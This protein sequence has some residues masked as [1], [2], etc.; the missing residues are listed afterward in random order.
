MKGLLVVLRRAGADGD[1][2]DNDGELS[3]SIYNSHFSQTKPCATFAVPAGYNN[4]AVSGGHIT[5]C[6]IRPDLMAQAMEAGD[7]GFAAWFE[8]QRPGGCCA[9]L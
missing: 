7:A 3:L 8:M 9:I 5:N 1:A 6:K 2:A 4:L